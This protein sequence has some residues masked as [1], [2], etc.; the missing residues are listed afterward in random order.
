MTSPSRI[1]EKMSRLEFY[2][3]SMIVLILWTLLIYSNSFNAAFVMDDRRVINDDIDEQSLPEFGEARTLVD[4]TFAFNY[5]IWELDPF[6]YHIFNFAVHLI[7]SILVVILVILLFSLPALKKHPLE[8]SKRLLGLSVG[9][10]FAS[11]PLQTMAVTYVIQRYASFAA[12]WYFLGVISYIVS[13]LQIV[14]S[15]KRWWSFGFGIVYF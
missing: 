8:Q 11:H 7:N 9:F 6:S 10:L 15:V 12:T 2:T 5:S 14:K 1:L 13:R 4:A 3:I